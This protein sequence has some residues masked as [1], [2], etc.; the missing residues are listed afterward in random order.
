[1]FLDATTTQ[2]Y[3]NGMG[4]M[5]KYGTNAVTWDGDGNVTGIWNHH[6]YWDHSDRLTK[7]DRYE[8]TENDC[9]Y[10]YIPGSWARY[11]RVQGGVTE[12][13]VYDG[14][15]VVGSYTSGGALN[16]RYLTPGLD[17]N[18]AETRSGST[19]YYMA[20]GLGSV[21]N[22]VDG[23]ESVQDT[24]DYY[25]F[26]NTL[27]ASPANV[28][29]PYRYTG[30][31]FESGSVLDTYYYRNRYYVSQ[32]G[33]FMSR[34]AA[35]ADPQRGWGYVDNSPGTGYDPYGLADPGY[36]GPGNYWHDEYHDVLSDGTPRKLCQ[37]PIAEDEWNREQ[38]K[39]KGDIHD[40]LDAAGVVDPTPVS[41]GLNA[42]IYMTEGR[43]GNGLLSLVCIIP[44]MDALKLA[45][46]ADD[47]GKFGAKHADDVAKFLG[48]HAD[49]AGKCVEP[50]ATPEVC[51]AA[52]K[53]LVK[54]LHKGAGTASQ[55]GTGS[56]A[57]AIRHELTTGEKV[58]GK[59]HSK[60]GRQYINALKNWIKKSPNACEADK[61]EA[62]KMLE[63]LKSAL[64]GQVMDIPASTVECV[65]RLIERVPE[66]R[67]M[68]QQHVQFNG[69]LLP[70]VFLGE[71]CG[72][73]EEQVRSGDVTG[74]GLLRR[75]VDFFECAIASGDED[76]QEL[77]SVSFVENLAWQEDVF[78]R[79]EGLLGE[80]LRREFQTYRS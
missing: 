47:I 38:N 75:I 12:Y 39:C 50:V 59:F 68:Y 61:Q 24:Y 26:G 20:D 77:I 76:V 27:T 78:E 32:L 14:A 55:I 40:T 67:G 54:D 19:Y 7:F 17:A 62:R 1:M 28:A 41:D 34:D 21:R 70:H 51:D 52:L 16:A 65:Q 22:V 37:R 13:Y 30:R 79:I 8:G 66:L 72:Y 33:I 60:K 48:K 73:V 44:F 3:Y 18:L 29:N 74:Q 64:G 45:K 56:T 63:D 80:N 5:T 57:D 53:R 43:F 42:G 49:D 46:H 35:W 15:N 36:W 10:G 71:V 2:Y 31:E 58:G 23:S 9:T 69:E 25:A 11:K 4:E 6:Y